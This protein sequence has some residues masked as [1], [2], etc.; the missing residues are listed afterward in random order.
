MS[1][2][3][4]EPNAHDRDY[5]YDYD[6]LEDLG[7]FDVSLEPPPGK[8]TRTARLS[9]YRGRPRAS[10]GSQLPRQRPA[11]PRARS[12]RLARPAI[13][14]FGLHL[15][16]GG[17]PT[18]LRARFESSLA[19]DLSTI[20]VHRDGAAADRVAKHGAR[21]YA[22]G[23]DIHFGDGE[24]DPTSTEGQHLIAHE[25]AHAVQQS[26][27][28]EAPR[29]Q[30]KLAASQAHD[31]VERE[32][33]RA[34]EAMV[35]G[36]PFTLSAQPEGV[37]KKEP[38]ER[39]KE[40]VPGVLE[41]ATANV[42]IGGSVTGTEAIIRGGTAV[43]Q[44]Q[45]V[46]MMATVMLKPDVDPEPDE[47]QAGW[48]QTVVSSRRVAVYQKAGVTHHKNV[49]GFGSIRD[50]KHGAKDPWYV[51]PETLTKDKRSVFPMAEDQPKIS[52]PAH[53]DGAELTALEGSDNFLVS[54]KVGSDGDLSTIQSFTWSAPWSVRFNGP[55]IARGGKVDIGPAY[56]HP[57]PENEGIANKAGNDKANQIR[58]YESVDAAMAALSSGGFQA[59]VRDLPRHR[60]LDRGSYWNMISALWKSG[61]QI[62]VKLEPVMGSEAKVPVSFSADN[63]VDKGEVSTRGTY[64]A[65]GHMVYDPTS[66]VPGH[67]IYV[68]VNY[69]VLELAYP[70]EG[71]TFRNIK[72][73]DE[74][75]TT[76]NAVV[77][78]G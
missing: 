33:D 63:R 34:A 13:D 65:L 62:R 44:S 71:K 76:I 46:N 29:P 26:G 6:E 10:R 49:I 37:A 32:A 15:P 48:V 64:S 22:E 60:R 25:V 75:E 74:G 31:P 24:Y 43:A 55:G 1:K 14:P 45:G 35:R 56:S 73:D 66:L 57:D 77:S 36:D 7:D 51:P 8:M 19:T 9:K 78:V 50:A 41:K 11:R 27:G 2:E 21:A 5:E 52:F 70:Y 61:V 23:L 53:Q 40:R 67:S 17:L 72:V 54:L 68:S 47:I 3:H 30:F 58:T 38:E 12:N 42:T 4:R 16:G 69:Q 18:E 28:N 20:R 39:K 59:F